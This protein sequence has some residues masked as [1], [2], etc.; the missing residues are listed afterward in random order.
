MNIIKLYN[1]LDVYCALRK[2]L[3]IKRIENPLVCIY[4]PKEYA[5]IDF[6]VLNWQELRGYITVNVIL[7]TGIEPFTKYAFAVACVDQ[8]ST[9][10]VVFIRMLKNVII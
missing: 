6:T 5:V 7:L 8:T 1:L 9:H 2:K 3:Q 4:P 10:V